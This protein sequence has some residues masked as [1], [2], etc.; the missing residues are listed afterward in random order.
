MFMCTGQ[1]VRNVAEKAGQVADR[2]NLVVALTCMLQLLD[3][4]LASGLS[5]SVVRVS[6]STSSS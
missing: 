2:W 3:D 6:S 4:G 5:V 1:R